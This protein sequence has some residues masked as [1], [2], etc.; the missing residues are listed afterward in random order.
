MYIY[1]YIFIHI[2]AG[3]TEVGGF[4]HA[5][6]LKSN[7]ISNENDEM[8]PRWLILYSIVPGLTAALLLQAEATSNHPFT[9]DSC[10]NIAFNQ[11]ESNET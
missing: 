5:F 9:S 4:K 2:H 10:E 6:L 7:P 1:V 11:V 3:T 8:V